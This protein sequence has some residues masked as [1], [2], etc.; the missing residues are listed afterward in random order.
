MFPLNDSIKS[1]KK[2]YVN[3]FIII[4]NLVVFFYQISLG[5]SVRYFYLEYGLIP[6]KFFAPLQFVSIDEKIVPFFTS[7][8]IHGGWF[9]L[10]SN[11][12]F[13][14]IFGDN[15][16]DDLGHIRY[17]FVYLLFGLLAA[18]TQ[19]VMFSSSGVPTIGASGAV[20]GVMG[21]YFIRYPH[22]TVKTLVIFIFFITVV[23]IPA[24]IF[25]GLWFFIQFMSGSAQAISASGGGV[26]WWA[27]I[28][29]F[30]AG[31]VICIIKKYKFS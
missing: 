15:V 16:E 24:I 31:I 29:G 8:F 1:L 5:D 12:Y 2:P 13:L 23:E 30:I 9:H 17:F 6:L 26:A 18:V 14:F 4:L 3:T 7:M 20:A 27:H 10:L 22:A 11:L 28:G 21:Y 25:L 19:V